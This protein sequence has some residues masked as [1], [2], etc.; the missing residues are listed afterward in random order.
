MSRYFLPKGFLRAHNASGHNDRSVA[1]GTDY[2]L[3]QAAFKNLNMEM[4]YKK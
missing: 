2:W 4:L 3:F 1:L